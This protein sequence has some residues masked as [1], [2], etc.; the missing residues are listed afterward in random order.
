MSFECSI[1]R[2]YDRYLEGSVINENADEYNQGLRDILKR[3]GNIFPTPVVFP[4]NPPTSSLKRRREIQQI[5]SSEYDFIFNRT[6]LHNKTSNNNNT[7]ANL[8]YTDLQKWVDE[9]KPV[10]SECNENKR[11][12]TNSETPSDI[13]YKQRKKAQEKILKCYHQKEVRLE[14]GCLQLSSLPKSIGYLTH[15]QELIL[16]ENNL[17]NLPAEI[18]NLKNLQKLILSFNPLRTLPKEITS[19]INLRKLE[20]FMCQLISLPE[21][22][23]NL[24]NLQE[25]QLSRNLLTALPKGIGNLICLEKLLISNN[26]LNGDLPK[27]VGKLTELKEPFLKNNCLHSL[28]QEIGDLKNLKT[29]DL[30]NNELTALPK[31]IG[32]LAYL[33][34]L[35]LADNK[36]STLP[37]EISNLANLRVLRLKTNRLSNL[38][39]GIGNLKNLKAISLS[40]NELSTLPEGI[41]NL[42]NLKAICLSQNELSTLPEDLFELTNLEELYLSTNQLS[43]LPKEIGKLINLKILD[44]SQNKLSTL[45]KEI[46]ELTN[47]QELYLLMNQ[48]SNLP[49]EIG[50][51]KQ[52]KMLNLFENQ[53]RAVPKEIGKLINLELLDLSQNKLSTLPKEIFGLTCLAYLYLLK[54]QLRSLPSLPAKTGCSQSLKD[55]LLSSNLIST[56][57]EKIFRLQ[58][59]QILDLSNNLISA[60]S[61]NI[62][63]RLEQRSINYFLDDNSVSQISHEIEAKKIGSNLKTLLKRWLPSD[64]DLPSIFKKLLSEPSRDF[65][66]L[67][68]AR[69]EN[70]NYMPA[71]YIQN[72]EEFRA[73]IQSILKK[74]CKNKEA[75]EILCTRARAATESCGDALIHELDNLELALDLSQAGELDYQPLIEFLLKFHRK[76]RL[77]EY[78]KGLLKQRPLNESIETSL[79]FHINLRDLLPNSAKNMTHRNCANISNGEAPGLVSD[80][81]K[82]ITE[83][84][85]TLE[86]QVKI[87]CRMDPWN[88]KIKRHEKYKSF[89]KNIYR[90]LANLDKQKEKLK[91]EQAY[92]DSANALSKEIEQKKFDLTKKILQA[93]NQKAE[94]AS[95]SSGE[96]L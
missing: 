77:D 4:E 46:F 38:P 28:P 39:E 74:G 73:R 57:P 85:Q 30:S 91:N 31:E 64:V 61:D 36:L 24:K 29:L 43:N 92:I 3:E 25:F 51:L 88:K 49:K 10:N 33:E 81:R 9:K 23:G 45:P 12:R 22:I 84:C 63:T 32:N 26:Q 94:S 13:E 50:Q 52:L 93:N 71:D 47:L 37:E 56:F 5:F 72:P 8:L 59:L 41:G 95:S 68:L 83:D 35:F 40:Q 54:N 14:L 48:L 80:A 75:R 90:K 58:K 21:E 67:L 17:N 65:L 79:F 44:L 53:L 7:L 76:K 96:K 78:V 60:V 20:L 70:S 86:D 11:R 82:F 2:G 1:Q 87:L 6:V 15:L 16:F 89:M 42:K 27:E 55:L 62:I 18:C 19:L 69:L 66:A 34:E